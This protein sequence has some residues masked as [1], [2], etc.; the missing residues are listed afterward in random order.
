MLSN[1]EKTKRGSFLV[2]DPIENELFSDDL[3]VV[4]QTIKDHGGG[5]SIEA[6]MEHTKFSK[7]RVMN[8][9]ESGLTK[10]LVA[11]NKRINKRLGEHLVTLV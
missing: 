2:M 5:L 10:K 3:E 6:I 11:M 9:V 4:V 1:T 8:L 7:I